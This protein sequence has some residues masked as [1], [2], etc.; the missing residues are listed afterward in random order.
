MFAVGSAGSDPS[1]IGVRSAR[2]R[3]GVA[4]ARRLVSRCARFPWPSW[5]RKDSTRLGAGKSL[6]VGREGEYRARDRMQRM[7]RATV[8]AAIGHRAFGSEVD[9]ARMTQRSTATQFLFHG[10]RNKNSFA[11][12]AR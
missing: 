11:A 2:I 1:S 5:A 6:S 7:A 9:I 10:P 12:P 4:R 3:G 8:Q